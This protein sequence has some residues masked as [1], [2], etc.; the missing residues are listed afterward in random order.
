MLY[1]NYKISIF[2]IQVISFECDEKLLKGMNVSKG[3]WKLCSYQNEIVKFFNK[4]II[5]I[6]F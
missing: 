1:L 2:L 3:F 4:L 5:I 6:P